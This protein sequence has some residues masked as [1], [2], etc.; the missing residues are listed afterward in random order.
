MKI[1]LDYDKTYDQDPDFWE[2]F[3]FLADTYGHDVRIVTARNVELD[4]IDDKVPEDVVI[5][6]CDGVA[7]KWWCQHRG[8]FWE[9]D[10]WID[11]KPE[12]ILQNGPLTEEQIADWRKNRE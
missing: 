12:G 10:V 3:I 11:D 7:K 1:A 8:D 2:D 5:M 9:P 6:Y 4:N